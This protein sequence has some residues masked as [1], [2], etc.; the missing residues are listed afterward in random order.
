MHDVNKPYIPT[1]SLY[2]SVMYSTLHCNNAQQVSS[3]LVYPD[4]IIDTLHNAIVSTFFF[5]TGDY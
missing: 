1:L 5:L 3:E 4:Q 2:I